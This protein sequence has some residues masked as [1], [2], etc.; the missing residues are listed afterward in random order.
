MPRP[1][2][3]PPR[4][5]DRG[6]AGMSAVSAHA[7]G[8][9]VWFTTRDCLRL[10]AAYNAGGGR[11]ALPALCLAGLTRNGRDFA[12]LAEALSGDRD[13]WR[14]DYRGRGL[15]DHDPDWRNY[16]PLIEV[17]DTLD[18]MTAQGLDRV[19][20]IGTSRGGILA[21]I[22]A[23]VRPT[24]L[25]AVVL[26]D[27]GPVIEAAGLKRI[28]SYVGRMQAPDTWSEAAAALE[29]VNRAHF[30]SL[31][32]DD[33]MQIARQWFNEKDGRPVQSYDPA[34]A[35]SFQAYA[36]G[37]ALPTLW[38]QYAALADIPLMAIRGENSDLLSEDT[39]REMKKRRPDLVTLVAP[40]EGHAPLLSDPAAIEAIRAFIR[41]ADEAGAAASPEVRRPG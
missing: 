31:G 34:L 20:L 17:F 15:S 16:N 2:P 39:L 40:G 29:R 33:W 6:V 7:T 3:P 37:A 32:G 38:P 19:A 10:H 22:M 12:A 21:M 23:A 13:V 41:R 14:L 8:Q 35:R 27:I 24:A 5:S 36:S 28:A 25:G 11:S 9:S 26:N 18:F 30:T 4:S 1:A